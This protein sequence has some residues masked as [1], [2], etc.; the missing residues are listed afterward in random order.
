M[1]DLELQEP[2]DD[3][4][5]EDCTKEACGWKDH[6]PAQVT[7]VTIHHE[8]DQFLVLRVP[9]VKVEQIV[10]SKQYRKGL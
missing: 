6:G 9:R 4:S 3:L 2:T 5:W 8:P 10:P 1:E 7:L